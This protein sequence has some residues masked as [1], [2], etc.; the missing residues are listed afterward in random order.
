MNASGRKSGTDMSST[1]Q[2]TPSPEGKLPQKTDSSSSDIKTPE[3][4]ETM[5]DVRAGVDHLDHQL[6]A[7]MARRQGY[8]EAAARIKSDFE[9]V[10]VPWRIE[11]V[12]E[13]VLA[14]AEKQGLSPRIAEPVWRRLIEQSIAHEAEIWKMLRRNN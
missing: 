11:Q 2:A 8:M 1:R 10:R 12:V 5:A 7:L 4:C 3:A 14:E 6:V 9:T 13:N